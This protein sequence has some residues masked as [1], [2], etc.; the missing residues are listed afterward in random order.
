M[1]SIARNASIYKGMYVYLA[2]VLGEILDVD[3]DRESE[4]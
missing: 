3:L 4:T 1:N 2:A